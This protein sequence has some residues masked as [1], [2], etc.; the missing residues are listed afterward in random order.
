MEVLNNYS[1]T[2]K[3][4]TGID[5]LLWRLAVIVV[6]L[7]VVLAS[8][9]TVIFLEQ[10]HPAATG[11]PLTLRYLPTSE[12]IAPDPH[13]AY[14]SLRN[15]PAQQSFLSPPSLWI[16]ADLP[17]HTLDEHFFVEFPSHY[18][19][20]IACWD[21]Q[22][23]TRLDTD[24]Q[25][26]G[27]GHARLGK[28]GMMLTLDATRSGQALLCHAEF[29]QRAPVTAT[30]WTM[31]EFQAM[32]SKF[33]YNLGMLQGGVLTLAALWLMIAL[34]TREGAYA[35]LAVWLVANLRLGAFVIG[36]DGQWLGFLLP[37]DIL[38][39]L[40]NLTASIYYLFT[41]VLLTH[42][43][44]SN[45]N[46]LHPQLLNVTKVSGL[47]IFGLAFLTPGQWFWPMLGI[48]AIL[49]LMATLILLADAWDKA[50]IVVRFWQITALCLAFLVLISLS[51]LI[52]FGDI[53]QLNTTYATITML[54]TSTVM[55]LALLERMRLNRLRHQQI[56]TELATNYAITPIGMFTLNAD[57]K[58]IRMNHVFRDMLNLPADSSADLRWTDY[59]E[60]VDWQNLSAQTKADEDVE[61]SARHSDRQ[62]RKRHFAI[63]AVLIDDIVEGSIQD[64]TAHTELIEQLRVVSGKDPVTDG[65]NLRGV[66]E[67]VQAALQGLS[68][69]Q[70]ASLACLNLMQFKNIN[71][72]FGYTTGDAMLRQT[73]QLITQALRRR[74]QL[75]RLGGDEFAI[76]FPGQTV[77]DVEGAVKSLTQTINSHLFA[78]GA[79]TI[80]VKAVVGLIDLSEDI[81]SAK[82]ALFAAGRACRDARRSPSHVV[83]YARGSNA[84]HE[85]REL[86]RL[87]DQLETG[88]TPPGFRLELQPILPLQNHQDSWSFE[89]LLRVED[90]DGAPLPAGRFIAAAEEIGHI[91]TI[92][93][94]VL[95]TMLSWLDTNIKKMPWLHLVTINLSGVSLNSEPFVQHLF[96]L[97]DRYKPLAHRLVIEMTESAA[98]ENL[99]RT[100][101]LMRQIQ[102]LGVKVGLDDFGSGYTSFSYLRH[103]KA[104]IV[105]IDGSLIC[106]MLADPANTAI[107]QTIIQL[108]RHLNMKCIA[109]W[110]E[111]MKTLDALRKLGVDHVQGFVICKSLPLDVVLR[112]HTLRDFLDN[113]T[114]REYAISVLRRRV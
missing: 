51:A 50:R 76:V 30:L 37:A 74:H 34:N 107:V 88:T 87:F 109:E 48:T 98:I 16:L 71:N 43:L 102:T 79:H 33:D 39:L 12:H 53:N 110:V 77:D 81:N 28:R 83:T 114:V 73:S 44:Q 80:S 35:L 62:G 20:D 32:S 45:D 67:A 112:G 103:L 70:P 57:R 113:G 100:Q 29:S 13:T 86:L 78:V 27:A 9:L 68:K 63:R 47:V 49:A 54:V 8:V 25:A 42:L 58:F 111:D 3:R 24:T 89:T 96:R 91:T 15:E 1:D 65:L 41:V 92:D 19:T 21:A 101:I 26:A 108:A 60:P 31:D 72:L 75:G 97:L 7:C 94:W 40:R 69:G 93:T 6:P 105:K 82:E 55:G 104:D 106:N 5:R 95:E 17:V 11:Q 2:T 61:I 18:L 23:Q 4:L 66:E 64:I 38:P 10:T 22:T 14:Q 46:E 84:L 59:F 52:T 85:H 99:E 90:S 36:W 56:K